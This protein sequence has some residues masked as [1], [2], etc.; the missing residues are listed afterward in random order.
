MMYGLNLIAPP[1]R[2]LGVAGVIAGMVV[3]AA[4]AGITDPGLSFSAT[5]LQGTGSVSIAL[6]QGSPLPGGGW[7]WALVG[8]PVPI[9]GP[10]NVVLGTINQGTATLD[11]TGRVVATSFAVTAGNS[12]TNFTVTSALVSFP[13]L[14]NPLGRTSAGL[15]VTDNT[16]NGASV[17][18]NLLGG[19]VFT[20]RY[21]GQAP[22]GSLFANLIA[23]PLVEPTGFGSESASASF[24]GAPG[25][26]APIAGSVSSMST[27][28]D[29]TV[30][31]NDQAS[32]TSVF[33]L[34][35]SP[36]TLGLLGLSGL[37]LARRRR[38]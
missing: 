35:P 25:A 33:V 22:A 20:S 15:T 34:V 11:D 3:G 19:S 4:N 29:F 12:N 23:G 27:M 32:G 26:F 37:A 30:T 7:Q 17:S 1:R 10:G 18:G 31:Q 13:S 36:G 8:A 28:W 24:P 6:A 38:A 5:N 21:N 9:L 2:T 14:L 16:G